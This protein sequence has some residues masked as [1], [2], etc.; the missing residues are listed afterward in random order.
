MRDY[1]LDLVEHTHDLGC[2]DLVKITGT[3]KETVIDGIAED[4][5]VVVQGRFLTPVADFIGT[6]GMPNLTK[7]KILLNLQEYRENAEIT[8]R[9]QERNGEQ[10]P[11]GLHFKNTAGDFK[12]DYRFMTSEI[13]A[14]KLKTAKFRGA[15]W[16]IEFEPTIAGIHRLKM[17]A[18]ANV[19]ESTFQTRTD[20]GDLKFMF[21]DHSTHAG[22][23][24]FH[25]GITGELKRPWAWPVKQIIS[26]MDLTGDKTVRMSDD[27][28]AMISVNSGIAEYNYILP[29][30]SK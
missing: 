4:R 25:P 7:L 18:Q 6:F 3:A 27:G 30:Q 28:A 20:A 19:E 5:S 17:Q 24:V 2:I 26:I 22:E 8:V 16:N 13:V 14:E 15:N 1:L 29:A 12:N 9:R 23:F 10:A 11:V 21:G